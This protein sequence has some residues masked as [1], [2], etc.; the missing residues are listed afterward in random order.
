MP[1]QTNPKTLNGL[2]VKPSATA[3][4]LGF[5]WAL[6]AMLVSRYWIVPNFIPSQDGHILGDP[7]FYHDLALEQV[8]I[9]RQ[10]GWGAFELH[11]AQQ[12]TAGVTSLLYMVY[13][14]PF[15]VVVLNALLHG[16]ACAAVARLL[17][18]WFS[19]TVSLIATI[20]LILSL[21]NIF[22]L[23][24]INKESYVIAG[25]TLFF[26][27][28]LLSL[29]DI[30]AGKVGVLWIVVALVGIVLIYIP[31]PHMNQMLMLGFLFASILVIG[32]ALAT[33]RLKAASLALL[34]AVI[35]G[36]AFGYFS[37]GG[38]SNTVDQ[39][40]AKAAD[41]KHQFVQPPSDPTITP[42]GQ[43]SL[44][45]ASIEPSSQPQD[46]VRAEAHTEAHT[47][48]HT[49]ARTEPPT[50]PLND[51][52]KEP[53][54]DPITERLGLICYRKLD[55]ET[56]QTVNWLPAAIN[57]RIKALADL[58]CH[59]HE[60]HDVQ[61]NAMTKQSIADADVAI[62]GVMDMIA[63]APRGLQLGFFGPLPSQWPDGSFL[64]SFFYTAVPI[65]MVFFY[66]AMA[67]AAIWIVRNKAWLALPLFAI[68]VI[69]LWI[70]G[71][72]TSFFGSLFRYRYPIWIILLCFGAA[73][74][75]AMTVFRNQQSKN[76]A[77]SLS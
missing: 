1:N 48:A 46:N 74:L 31:R 26:L 63:Y 28:Y 30:Y 11:F 77:E 19:P 60:L 64:K 70:L 36:V 53:Q 43:T 66:I 39:M 71:M 24:Q 57:V 44:S 54:A 50:E 38:L 52:I 61:D 3:F 18:I 55:P 41:P 65:M 12:G 9:I 23:A 37:Q 49:D 10:Q 42:E 73:A 20:P 16:V 5:A 15:L 45:P 56:W 14:S 6:F 72:S 8:E 35:I 17:A 40:I 62:E 13:P 22:W 67:F 58:R 2:I 32:L 34:Q 27:G 33:K 4:W 76:K 7:V 51:P 69:P 68:S 29:K 21:V 47:D 25:C 75:L 59:N